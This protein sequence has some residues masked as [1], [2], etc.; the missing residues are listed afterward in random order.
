MCAKQH[1]MPS[2]HEHHQGRLQ[3]PRT[4]LLHYN[5]AAVLPEWAES[6]A[7]M[8]VNWR[9]A[10]GKG[11]AA[12]SRARH[13]PVSSVDKRNNCCAG[14]CLGVRR[15]NLASFEGR[16]HRGSLDA[17]LRAPLHYGDAETGSDGHGPGAH[18]VGVPQNESR[19]YRAGRIGDEAQS[20]TSKRSSTK[21]PRGRS[22]YAVQYD[23]AHGIVL[24]LTA[25]RIGLL[26]DSSRV[27]VDKGLG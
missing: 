15:I 3:V 4:G 13:Q 7:R 19:R 14:S 23:P 9:H 17:C 1:F 24:A 26:K 18:G 20:G 6:H 25:H 22:R 5:K 21:Q 2:S 10:R 16:A 12:T 8:G 11:P 27:H